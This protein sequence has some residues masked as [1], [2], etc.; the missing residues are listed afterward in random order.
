MSSPDGSAIA[1]EDWV[2]VSFDSQPA[3][4]P[5]A[6]LHLA[7]ATKRVLEASVSPLKKGAAVETI[8]SNTL[9]TW[10]YEGWSWSPDGRNILLLKDHMTRPVLIDVATDTATELP[11][12]TDSNPSWQRVAP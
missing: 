3:E 2:W 9:R 1:F 7:S 10:C 6:V 11:W 4:T 5:I 8:T 12:V